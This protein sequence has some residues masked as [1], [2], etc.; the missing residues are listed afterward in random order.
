M[1]KAA[2]IGV[3]NVA[4]KVKKMYVGVDGV[5]RKVKKGYIGV[6]G[7]ARLFYTADMFKY[8]GEWS[9]SPVEID[10]A[11][12]DLYTLTSSG[13]LTLGDD[14]QF[15]MCGGGASGAWGSYSRTSG[16]TFAKAGDG[17]YGGHFRTGTVAS[18]EYA[19]IIGA[20][21]SDHV[22]SQGGGATS[23]SGKAAS[24]VAEGGGTATSYGSITAYGAS[25]GGGGGYIREG[26]VS[27]NTAATACG[28]STIPFDLTD[29]K[30]H[31]AGGGG[32]SAKW[33]SYEG[34]AFYNRGG[35]GGSNGA[36]GARND[37]ELMDSSALTGSS[38]SGGR[39]GEYGGGSGAGINYGG[40]AGNFYGAGGGGS[41]S[42][43]NAATLSQGN[44]YSGAKGG[45]Q[46]VCYILL[47]ATA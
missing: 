44:D 34:E 36:K 4:R 23:I 39:G 32:G 37:S 1:S 24:Y 7:V 47:P 20:G 15:W 11:A 46:G 43:V 29:M 21:G 16:N 19:V 5:A 22:S 30:K 31:C 8:T 12:F 13:T 42:S 17:G 27:S 18:G 28:I 33:V 2:Y 10:G 3:G 35:A 6:N 41:S 38:Y 9:V 45:Y 40:R 14:A 25:T 26:V